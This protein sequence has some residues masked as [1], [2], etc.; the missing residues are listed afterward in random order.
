MA[1]EVVGPELIDDEKD[2]EPGA[3]SV[4]GRAGGGRFLG[5]G[6]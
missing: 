6:R 4:F 1:I 5:G 3:G 2:Q